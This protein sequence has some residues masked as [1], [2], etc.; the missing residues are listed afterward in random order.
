MKPDPKPQAQAGAA[1]PPKPTP[2][3]PP[4]YAPTIQ[5]PSQPGSS[6][7]AWPY[8]FA[9]APSPATAI[10]RARSWSEANPIPALILAAILFLAVRWAW[11][12]RDQLLPD[13]HPPQPASSLERAGATRARLL[14]RYEAESFREAAREIRDGTKPIDAIRK[15]H[16]K[17]WADARDQG[18]DQQFKK[19]LASVIPEGTA[20][21]SIEQRRRYAETLEQ[22][23]AGELG[24]S[25][26]APRAA[27]RRPGIL[28]PSLYWLLF[29]DP[30][31]DPQPA[32]ASDP[33]P[34][35][36]PSEADR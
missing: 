36:E 34:A 26:A 6:W 35:P 19:S 5:V 7:P 27:P 18:F 31:R 4:P 10:N 15:E 11:L 28:G 8:S 14:P 12:N 21:P 22:I 16:S 32:P 30:V 20:N 2:P 9:S 3:P 23:A 13:I 24:A 33:E 1:I 29:A 17:R 25:R